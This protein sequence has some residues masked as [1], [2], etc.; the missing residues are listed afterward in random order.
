MQHNLCLIVGKQVFALSGS[1]YG[2]KKED[3]RRCLTTRKRKAVEEIMGFNKF[4]E[5]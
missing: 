5:A 3:F 2:C 4:S 1:A